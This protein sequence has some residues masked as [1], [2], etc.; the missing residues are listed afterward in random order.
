MADRRPLLGSARGMR[1]AD[2][3]S[4]VVAACV[5]MAVVAVVAFS[6]RSAQ[7]TQLLDG[8]KIP[9]GTQTLLY[10]DWRG[11]SLEAVDEFSFSHTWAGSVNVGEREQHLVQ[12]PQLALAPASSQP[13]AA[14]SEVSQSLKSKYGITL[15]G[16]WAT[17]EAAALH[18]TLT[19]MCAGTDEIT[20]SP[21]ENC[22]LAGAT[23]VSIF[24]GA[25]VDD[26]SSAPGEMS[27]AKAAF[28]LAGG[29]G[30]TL[31]GV[32]GTVGS[33]RLEL[34]LVKALTAFG[35]DKAVVVQLLQRKFAATLDV[36]G[37]V[38]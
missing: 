33:L 11:V 19:A 15:S 25:L 21:Q 4:R 35:R 28:R 34:A 36:E 10:K 13:L 37:T 22:G 7:P 23:A 1:T 18:Q 24:P 3:M 20:G 29:G 38:P 6:S 31:D 12:E 14:D 30:A 16:T 8:L 27:I 26:V 2:L 17:G 5:A 32:E 9:A